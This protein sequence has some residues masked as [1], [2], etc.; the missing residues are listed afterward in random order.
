MQM[1]AGTSF[2]EVL[3]SIVFEA[4]YKQLHE[5]PRQKIVPHSRKRGYLKAP[6]RVTDEFEHPMSLVYASLVFEAVKSE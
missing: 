3:V 2:V 1:M 6:S 5:N 4:R